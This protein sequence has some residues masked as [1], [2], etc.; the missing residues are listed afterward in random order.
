MT[1]G[2][3]ISFE[4]L[5]EMRLKYLTVTILKVKG[6]DKDLENKLNCSQVRF[7]LIVFS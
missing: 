2:Q 7:S 3:K 5:I 4:K 6:L 1:F